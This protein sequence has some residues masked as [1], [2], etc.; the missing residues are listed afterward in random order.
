MADISD[1]QIERLQKG[2]AK[3]EDYL[4][5]AN[6]FC[7]LFER[8]ARKAGLDHSNAKDAA[9]ELLLRMFSGGLKKYEHR[10]I[11]SLLRYLQ[12]CAYNYCIDCKRGQVLDGALVGGTTVNNLLGQIPACGSVAGPEEI[13]P[14]QWIR[15]NLLELL[16]SQQ[17]PSADKERRELLRAV[18]LVG[19]ETVWKE[20]LNQVLCGLLDELEQEARETYGFQQVE[21][22]VNGRAKTSWHAFLL[23]EETVLQA[24][25]IALL[26]DIKPH[27]VYMNAKRIRDGLSKE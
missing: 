11:K 9:Q 12:R 27:S 18:L 26:L 14:I 16:L 20:E 8:V 15:E 1:T 24:A 2:E 5:F 17:D 22:I 6:L 25:D 21:A 3:P 19:D 23:L 7:P 13:A 4:D 10:N